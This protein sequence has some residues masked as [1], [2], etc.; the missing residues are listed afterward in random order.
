VQALDAVLAHEAQ[1]EKQ[2]K[3]AVS[4]EVLM[5]PAL[6]QEPQ[7]AALFTGLVHVPQAILQG[8]QLVVVVE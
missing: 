1:P 6:L 2:E 3:H 8:S 5:N 7:V 4:S